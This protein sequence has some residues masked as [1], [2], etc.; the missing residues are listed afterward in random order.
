M[1]HWMPQRIVAHVKLC[2]LALMIQRA[3]EI[4]AELPWR[5]ISAALEPLK[6]VRYQAE[7]QTILQATKTRPETVEI[8]K[9]LGVSKPQTILAVS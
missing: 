1:F 7:G 9:K 3:A 2:V 4:A 8:L 6:A 5:Q